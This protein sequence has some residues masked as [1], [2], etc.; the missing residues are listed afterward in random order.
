ME[1]EVLEVY[2]AIFSKNKYKREIKIKHTT[3]NKIEKIWMSG[4]L[5]DMISIEVG[6]IYIID[7]K[8]ATPMTQIKIFTTEEYNEKLIDQAV[9][10]YLEEISDIVLDKDIT[11]QYQDYNIQEE[12]YLRIVV[13]TII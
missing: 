10:T 9:N 11:I 4:S 1:F 6:N 5:E 13:T 2:K 8:E 3:S 7:R 12:Q